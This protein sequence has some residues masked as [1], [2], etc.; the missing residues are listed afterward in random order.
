MSLRV[1]VDA[2]AWLNPRGDGR[3][4]RNATRR[5]VDLYREIEWVLI[6]DRRTAEQ[7]ELPREARVRPVHQ[8]RPPSTLSGGSAR[9]VGDVVRLTRSVRRREL[10]VFLAPSVYS[11]FP[12]V[13]VPT[14]VGLHDATATR[15]PDSVLPTRRS[16]LMWRAKQ[17]LALRRAHRIF[18][19]SQA[20]RAAISELLGVPQERVAVVPEAPDPAFAPRP[21]PAVDAALLGLK[22]SRER[23]YLLFASGISPHKGLDT[24]LDAYAALRGRRVLPPLVVAGSLDGPYASATDAVAKQVAALELGEA[25]HFPGFVTDE[26]LACL[27]TGAAA[28]VVPSRDEG[29]GLPAVE[30]AACGAAIVLSD[31]GAHRET[32]D[33]AALFFPPG[34]AAGLAARLEELLDA[35]VATRS[36]GERALGAAGRLSWDETARRLRAL[37]IGAA[38]PRVG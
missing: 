3:F 22:I 17:T 6:C 15:L 16:R 24:L 20:S 7:G 18:T 27:Y 13:G 28:V 5:L 23:G 14:V 26:D 30:A 35:P 9:R 12:V 4:V 32:L 1:G 37:L 8:R 10:D 36:L 11:Y 2:T 25:V 29:F 33:G 31:I 21:S 19:V 38:G 34:D